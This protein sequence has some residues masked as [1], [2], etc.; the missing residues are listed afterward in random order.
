MTDNPRIDAS[1]IA[2]RKL[3]PTVVPGDQLLSA[4]HGRAKIRKQQIRSCAGNDRRFRGFT[5]EHSEVLPRCKS[6]ITVR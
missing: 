5:S 3:L 6:K 2:L 1:A 4:K